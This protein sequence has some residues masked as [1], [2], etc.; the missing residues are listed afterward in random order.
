M[1]YVAIIIHSII[2]GFNLSKYGT[3]YLKFRTNDLI[4]YLD[5]LKFKN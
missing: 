2:I 3:T 4:E 1:W 5:I